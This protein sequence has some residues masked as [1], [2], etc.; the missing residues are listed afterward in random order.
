[1]RHW[2]VTNQTN[3]CTHAIAYVLHTIPS[4]LWHTPHKIHTHT[5]WLTPQLHVP[6]HIDTSPSSHTLSSTP[7]YTTLTHTHTQ[8]HTPLRQKNWNVSTGQKNFTPTAMM[9]SWNTEDMRMGGRAAIFWYTELL[10]ACTKRKKSTVK[11][12]HMICNLWASYHMGD[13]CSH[14]IGTSLLLSPHT[15]RM[16]NLCSVFYWYHTHWS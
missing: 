4:C 5:E 10:K 14:W 8:T 6:F 2:C 15:C 16:H 11:K 3:T 9:Y 12:G 1:M 7:H 13:R